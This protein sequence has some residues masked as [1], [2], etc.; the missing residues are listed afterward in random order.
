MEMKKK[1]EL[2]GLKEFIS[3]LSRVKDSMLSIYRSKYISKHLEKR[4]IE[5][6]D[7]IMIENPQH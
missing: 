6:P 4:C 2:D 3:E 7:F 5:T 1:Y